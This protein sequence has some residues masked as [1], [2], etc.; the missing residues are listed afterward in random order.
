MHLKGYYYAT[1]AANEGNDMSVGWTMKCRVAVLLDHRMTVILMGLKP[2]GQ[3][4]CA[5]V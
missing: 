5:R 4:D 2:P 3:I 1:K